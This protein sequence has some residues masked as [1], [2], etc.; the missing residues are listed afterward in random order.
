[1]MKNDLDSFL[2]SNGTRLA[3]KLQ[4][5]LR[6]KKGDLLQLVSLNHNKDKYYWSIIHKEFILVNGCSEMYLLPWGKDENGHV[7]VYSHYLFSQ[8]A[9]FMVPEEEIVLLGFN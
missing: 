6:S 1:M 3:E 9:V 8:S 7:Y 2:N 5:F 4:S